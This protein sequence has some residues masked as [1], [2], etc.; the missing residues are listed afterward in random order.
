[1]FALD[2]HRIQPFAHAPPANGAQQAPP[3][4]FGLKP[5]PREREREREYYNGGARYAE[6]PR[7]QHHMSYPPPGPAPFGHYG[8]YPPPP[9]E[10][11]GRRSPPNRRRLSDRLGD[12]AHDLPPLILTG[13]EGLPAKPSIVAEPMSDRPRDGPPPLA[14]VKQ[15]PRAA[16]GRKVSYLDMDEVAEGDVELSY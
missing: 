14:K 12:R 11:Y 16:A 4:A 3:Q 8:E 15:D 13:S 7:P 1:M 6:P 10:Y 9:S 5:A 2:P